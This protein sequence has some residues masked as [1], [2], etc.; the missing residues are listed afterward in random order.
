MIN[1]NSDYF[2]KQYKYDYSKKCPVKRQIL[3]Y[4]NS[5]VLEIGCGIGGLAQLISVEIPTF[6]SQKIF[7]LIQA[8]SMVFALRTGIGFSTL[9]IAKT[10][11]D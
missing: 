3:K 6:P 8:M 7:M 5:S 2:K 1:S 4:K 9:I 11:H 10:T